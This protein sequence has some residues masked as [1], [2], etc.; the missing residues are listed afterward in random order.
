MPAKPNLGEF[1]EKDGKLYFIRVDNHSAVPDKASPSV[2]VKSGI[3]PSVGFA[4]LLG[5]ATALVVLIPILCLV[6]LFPMPLL[7][8][9]V[10]MGVL[11]FI[12]AGLG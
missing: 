3:Y 10:G 1:V 12:Q 5:Y 6:I 7:A 2:V 9:L 11:K 8:L 4:C